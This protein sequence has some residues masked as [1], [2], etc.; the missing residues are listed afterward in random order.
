MWLFPTISYA[1]RAEPASWALLAFQGLMTVCCLTFFLDCGMYQN[2][3]VIPFWILQVV[4]MLTF[5]LVVYF[6]TNRHPYYHSLAVLSSSF[7]EVV[8]CNWWLWILTTETLPCR[9]S[10]G[11]YFFWS[12]S[13]LMSALGACGAVGAAPAQWEWLNTAYWCCLPLC[14]ALVFSPEDMQMGKSFFSS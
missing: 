8:I 13:L 11:A 10:T 2:G 4:I 6:P 5:S 3:R 9:G 7:L 12:L 1:M 14:L